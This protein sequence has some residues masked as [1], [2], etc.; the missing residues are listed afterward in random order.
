MKCRRRTLLIGLALVLL[1]AIGAGPVLM[2]PTSSQAERKAA[3]LRLGMPLGE[4]SLICEK[5]ISVWSA[6]TSLASPY[7][8]FHCRFA[9]GSKLTVRAERSREDVNTFLVSALQITPPE[10]PLTRLR[11]TLARIMPALEE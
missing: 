4:A 2:W 9:D 8:S 7:R 5:D 6:I 3:T 11:R 1:L 10:H